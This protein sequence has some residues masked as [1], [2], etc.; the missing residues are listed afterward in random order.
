MIM[1]LGF[2]VLRLL[3]D[4]SENEADEPLYDRQ[5]GFKHYQSSNPDSP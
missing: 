1:L 3:R 4:G 2:I 5:T